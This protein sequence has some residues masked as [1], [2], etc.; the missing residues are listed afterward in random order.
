MGGNPGDEIQVVHPFRLSF[1]F[2]IPVADPAFSFIE[3]EAFQGEKR[4]DHVFS[5]PLG[6]SLCLGPDPAVN[7]EP[8]MP[9]GEEAVRP[10]GAQQLLAHKI[11]QDLPAEELGQSR[12]V[13]PGDL[14]KDPGLIHSTLGHQETE[15]GVEKKT[16][17]RP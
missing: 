16:F 5:H 6:L 15:V 10:F 3:G 14:V 9:P 4:P 8:R 11:G 17:T 1:V 2:P 7:I 13:Y 12:V